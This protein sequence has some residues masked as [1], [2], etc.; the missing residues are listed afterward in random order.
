MEYK[1]D[2]HII[3]E[4]NENFFIE[5]RPYVDRIIIRI[6]KDPSSR[7]IAMENGETLLA[8]FEANPRELERMK[9]QEHLVVTDQG[10]AAIGPLVWL[11][12]N[13]Q[14]APTSDPAVRKAIAY[15]VDRDFII[16]A[17]LLGAPTE[18]RT[19]FHPGSPFYEPNVEPYDLDIDEANRI[20]DE[21]GYARG[22]DG[23]RFKLFVDFASAF[24]RPH[25]EYLKP[26]LKKIGIDM[27][28]R[29]SPDFP[30]WAKRVSTHDF[31]LT[32]DV[33][34]NWGDPVIGVHRT[35]LSTNIKKGS[36]VQHPGL[37]QPQ[38]GRAAGPGRD[39]ARPGQAHRDLLRGAEAAGG[40]AARV[41]GAHPAVPHGLQQAH[42]QSAPDHLGN[43]L[44][45][46]RDLRP[47]GVM[48]RPHGLPAGIGGQAGRLPA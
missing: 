37:R 34:F 4:R 1:R 47:A 5:G 43:L 31:D 44:A 2:Q 30:S 26:Q 46:R 40:R 27:T 14:R 9:K 32:W 8:T 20:L 15:A 23:M 7:T 48:R 29:A 3:L 39:G 21:A 28:V 11:A 18:A 41:L 22:D 42:R 16:N 12:F 13:H 6:I 33:V 45:A 19:G 24:T 35:Y 10:Y 25:A 36:L 17:L 38:G